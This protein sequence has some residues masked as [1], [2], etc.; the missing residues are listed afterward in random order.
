LP[1]DRASIARSVELELV[2]HLLD[3]IRVGRGV[4]HPPDDLL[5]QLVQLRRGGRLHRL[6]VARVGVPAV[7]DVVL[8]RRRGRVGRLP[9]QLVEHGDGERQRVVGG[10]R[11]GPGR[12][13]AHQVDAL[14]AEELLHV[15]QRGEEV[16]SGRLQD[17]IGALVDGV[18]RVDAVP[19]DRAELTAV[20]LL[21]VGQDR[22]RQRG[23]LLEHRPLLL[24]AHVEEPLVR[25][26]AGEGAASRRG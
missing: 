19:L 14:A 2:A 9:G 21:L 3:Q 10:A 26:P 25:R 22:R 11:G 23:L 4:S 5:G 17:L 7:V 8:R 20:E 15:A 12:A 6:P 13:H 24:V 1:D 18:E 16:L